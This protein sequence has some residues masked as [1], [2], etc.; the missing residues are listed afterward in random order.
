M[1]LKKRNWN[2]VY[3]AAAA[4]LTAF[5]FYAGRYELFS[6]NHYKYTIGITTKSFDEKGRKT[7]WFDYSIDGEKLEGTISLPELDIKGP[8]ARYFVKY[9]TKNKYFVELLKN[10]PVPEQ[11]TQAPK[12]GWEHIPQ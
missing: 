2:W 12:E 11:I 5:I 9:N 3:I 6:P 7:V 4:L 1:I 10:K 8:G